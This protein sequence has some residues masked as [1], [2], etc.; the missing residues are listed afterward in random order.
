MKKYIILTALL[1]IGFVE[2]KAQI[3]DADMIQIV[4][5]TFTMGNSSYTRETPI[6]NVS[7][8]NFYM[9]KNVITNA[10]FADFLN[11]YNS[12]VVLNGNY[13]GKPLFKED[14]WGIIKNNDVYQAAA[15][16]E[17]YP[18]IKVTWYGAD[19][20][21]KWA[22]GRLP[23]EAEW[24]YAAKGGINKNTYTY[25]GSSTAST[26]AWYYDNSGH[27]N[28]PVATKI[29]NSLGLFDMSGNVYEWCSD[30]FGRYNDILSS[31][32]DPAGPENGVSK[33]IRGGYRS[34]GSTDLHLTHRESISPEECYNFVGFRLV[35]T[36]LTPVEQ[37][38][39]DAIKI[40]PNPAKNYINIQTKEDIKSIEIVNSAGSVV[41]ISNGNVH[42]LSVNNLT[43]GTYIIKVKNNSNKYYITKLVIEK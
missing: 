34:L 31:T 2:I 27:T 38:K 40:Y 9:S 11:A 35:K 13:A 6:R 19:A 37:I 28:H 3:P 33:V 1:L 16:Y 30:W 21:C 7:I 23:T 4:G 43:N 26:V 41:S 32:T 22:G 39:N 25:S 15:G 36:S 18:V 20:Y 14:S 10:Q 17:N 5:G 8:S 24:E 12:S 29:A 42:V